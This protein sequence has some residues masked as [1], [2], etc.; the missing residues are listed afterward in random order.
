MKN[1]NL[2]SARL[3]N[4]EGNELIQISGGEIVTSFIISYAIGKAIDWYFSED[5]MRSA[6]E[7]NLTDKQ[8]WE[9]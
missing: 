3:S 7:L 1:L 9:Y 4:L 6:G 8:R 2:T 5:T